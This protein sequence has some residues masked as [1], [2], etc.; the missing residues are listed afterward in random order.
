MKQR[1][2]GR[3]RFSG[4]LRGNGVYVSLAVA[5]LAVGGL[6]VG[7]LLSTPAKEETPTPQIH[8]MVE[9]TVTG[10]PDERTTTTTTETKT[11]TTTTASEEAPDLFVLPVSNT[12]QKPFSAEAP[13][14]SETMKHWRLHLGVDFAGEAEQEVKALARGTVIE[15]EKDPLWGDVLVIDHS[16]GVLSRYCG[17]KATVKKG[18]EVEVAQVIGTLSEVPCEAA[19]APHLHLEMTI[20]GTPVD[21]VEA[22]ALEVRYADTLTE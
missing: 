5:L 18:D 9:Q 15:I 11:T 16:V 2:N 4:W 12:V 7:R 10:Q 13:Q 21:P 17:V 19:Q 3:G 22:I 6:G 20:D 14:Y 8:E 1:Y